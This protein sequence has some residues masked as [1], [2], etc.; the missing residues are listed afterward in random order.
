MKKITLITGGQRSGKSTFAMKLAKEYDSKP[1]YLAT[2]RIWDEE[3]KNRIEIHKSQRVEGW[4][5]IEED[6]FL[7]N[8]KFSNKTVL[9]DCVTLWSTNFF[10][11]NNSDVN[12]SLNLL[13]EEFIKFTDQDANFIFVTNEIGLGGIS[14]NLIQ[15][16]FTDLVGW[17]NQFIA[18]QSDDV[19]FMASGIPMKIK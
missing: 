8:H 13:K 2:S 5:N 3:H 11:D 10:F 18:E 9:I 19:Y 14:P 4:I 6:L 17:F 16:K 1:I 7:S 15:R 12:L